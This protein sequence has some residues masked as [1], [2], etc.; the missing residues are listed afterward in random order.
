[1]MLKLGTK[2]RTAEDKALQFLRKQGLK[3]IHRNYHCRLGEI[4]LVMKDSNTLVF[5]EVRYR[6]RQD[7]GGALESITASK[8]SKLRK[9]AEYFLQHAQSH[10]K[11]DEPACRF[12]IIS[13]TGAINKPSIDWLKN[14]F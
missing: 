4:D 10:P 12:D 2:G 9:T 6:A 13:M 1:M 7:Y 5:V 14:A 3:L 11:G 8:Q